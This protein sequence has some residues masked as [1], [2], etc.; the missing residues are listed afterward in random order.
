MKLSQKIIVGYYKTKLNS[1]AAVSPAKAAVAAFKLFCTPYHGKPKREAPP[2]F[3]KATKISFAF[4]ALTICGFHWVPAHPPSKKVLICH[5]FDSCC[6]K[7]DTYIDPLLREGFDVFAFDA[8]GHGISDGTTVNSLVYRDTILEINRLFGPFDGIIAH[9]L[10]GLATSLAA[11][12]LQLSQTRLVLI[13][14]AVEASTAIDQFFTFIPLHSKIRTEFN[15][16]IQTLGNQPVN[17]YSVTRAIQTFT[18]PVLWLHDKK[19]LV[20]PYSDTLPVQQLALPHITFITTNGL[21]HS[22]IYR[23]APIQKQVIDFISAKLP[24]SHA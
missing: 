13:A 8:P 20:C 15:Q 9:S 16:L 5:G 3:H 18:T 21:G 1:L 19:D 12:K 14:P 17:W 22:K 24:S 11:E 10:A 4:N 2:V 23:H 7:F 6:Y